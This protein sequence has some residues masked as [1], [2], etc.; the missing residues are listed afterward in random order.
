VAEESDTSRDLVLDGNAVAGLLFEV[1][2]A[3][4]TEAASECAHCGHGDEI[5]ALLA[6][7]RA[8]GVVLR[9]STCLEVMVRIVQT[10][11]GTYVDARGAAFTSAPTARSCL[12]S[13]SHEVGGHPVL[14]FLGR[15]PA[16]G[17]PFRSD[18]R[19]PRGGAPHA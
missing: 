15:A 16:S 5:G 7:T 17:S 13:T 19:H 9:C 4:M 3:E 11:H 1:F 12:Q 8:P 2:G 18:L 6:F 14:A 10:P